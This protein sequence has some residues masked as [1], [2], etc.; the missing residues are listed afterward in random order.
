MSGP[1]RTCEVV[2]VFRAASQSRICSNEADGPSISA[3]TPRTISRCLACLS[4]YR[5]IET[6]NQNLSRFVR[7]PD[8]AQGRLSLCESYSL[9]Q[10][11]RPALTCR[12]LHEPSLHCSF[13]KAVIDGRTKLDGSLLE[14]VVGNLNSSSVRVLL[15][16]EIS[17]GLQIQKASS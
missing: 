7:W 16:W 6:G 11:S 12:S 4:I 14:N 13:P 10:Q 9:T 2:P 5:R 3:A 8:R 17:P 15:W 1:P